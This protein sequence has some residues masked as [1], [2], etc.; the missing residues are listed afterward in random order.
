RKNHVS[1]DYNSNLQV[2][3]S[4]IQLLSNK[5]KLELVKL[6]KCY[7][8]L[9]M[10]N[11]KGFDELSGDIKSPENYM[12]ILYYKLILNIEATNEV[13]LPLYEEFINHKFK[14]NGAGVFFVLK[15]EVD[16]L[17]EFLVNQTPISNKSILN[18]LQKSKLPQIKRVYNKM[19]E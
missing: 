17:R 15:K 9:C 19:I 16:V 1:M 14:V 8:F 10:E 2:C 18:H 13:F 12:M 11:E 7:T 4:Y 6:Y 3:D 5:K